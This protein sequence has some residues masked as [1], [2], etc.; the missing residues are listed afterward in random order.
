MTEASDA[1]ADLQSRFTTAMRS[2]DNDVA[3]LLSHIEQHP[4]YNE[5]ID[6]A[7]RLLEHM[8]RAASITRAMLSAHEDAT[9]QLTK[10]VTLIEGISQATR[11]LADENVL[12]PAS[13]F[14]RMATD[15]T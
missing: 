3:R 6:R 7:K 4:R 10:L 5:K 14:S 2:V 12:H 8:E 1:L 15:P 13:I 9:D 11:S